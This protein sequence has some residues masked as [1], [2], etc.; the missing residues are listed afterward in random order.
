MNPQ[1]NFGKMGAASQIMP[2]VTFHNSWNN[3]KRCLLA[4]FL[5][6]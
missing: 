1:V 6:I 5:S 3:V 4:C 2:N